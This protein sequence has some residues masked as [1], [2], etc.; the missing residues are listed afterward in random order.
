MHIKSVVDLPIKPYLKKYLVKR[1]K[2]SGDIIELTFTDQIGFGIFVCS[3]LQKK[4]AYYHLSDV[5]A[6][7]NFYDEIGTSSIRIGLNGYHL[8][9]AG[10]TINRE[11]IYYIN[12]WLEKI[13]RMEL[14]TCINTQLRFYPHV[15]I[16]VAIDD[17]L[18]LYG[19]EEEDLARGTVYKFYHRS[20]KE[21]TYLERV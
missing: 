4:N 9:Y 10:M 20:K 15:V 2:S 5:N 6:I 17:F 19:I 16:T 12:K 21:Y 7:D 13:F 8:K 18:A 11:K 14:M 1:L 3:T